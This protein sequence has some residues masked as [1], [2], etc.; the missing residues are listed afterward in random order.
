MKSGNIASVCKV[1]LHTEQYN[2][3]PLFPPR[4]FLPINNNNNNNNNKVGGGRCHAGGKVPCEPVIV[5][6][7]VIAAEA[8]VVRGHHPDDN[9]PKPLHIRGDRIDVT[10]L[11]LP[12]ATIDC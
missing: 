7:V 8:V 2:R 4:F 1:L 6:V 12:I 3:S 11:L 5:V 10:M 9:R